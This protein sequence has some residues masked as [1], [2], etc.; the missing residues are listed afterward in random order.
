MIKI[1]DEFCK[2][3]H[4]IIQQFDFSFFFANRGLL[5]IGFRFLVKKRI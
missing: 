3:Y 5:L 2:L 1:G 4:I